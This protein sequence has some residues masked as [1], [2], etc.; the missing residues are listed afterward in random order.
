MIENLNIYAKRSLLTLNKKLFVLKII[1]PE[2]RE[3]IQINITKVK[4]ITKKQN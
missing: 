2:K 1:F 3:T 4:T